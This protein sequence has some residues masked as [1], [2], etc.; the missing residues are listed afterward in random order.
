LQEVGIAGLCAAY[1]TGIS[2]RDAAAAAGISY[3]PAKA[4]AK[5]SRE[6]P[7]GPKGAFWPLLRGALAKAIVVAAADAR[8]ADPKW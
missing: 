6:N 8:K 3:S 7:T 4:W 5:E 2:L 1:A